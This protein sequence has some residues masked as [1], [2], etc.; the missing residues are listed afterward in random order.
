MTRIKNSIFMDVVWIGG[1]RLVGKVDFSGWIVGGCILGGKL[2]F[3]RGLWAVVC[4]R[5]FMV[6]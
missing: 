4:W 1:S 2:F 5:E 3:F 6:F